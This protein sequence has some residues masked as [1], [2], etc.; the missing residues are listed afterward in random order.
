MKNLLKE[1]HNTMMDNFRDLGPIVDETTDFF[2][3]G[4]ILFVILLVCL[5]VGI[6]FGADII[7]FYTNH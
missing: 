2:M 5:A 4:L 3:Y 1:I 7:H 6:A